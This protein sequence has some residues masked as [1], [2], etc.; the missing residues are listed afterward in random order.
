TESG[1]R[2]LRVER[3]T[4]SVKGSAPVEVTYEFTRHGPVIWKSGDRAV[5]VRWVGSEPGTAGYLGALAVGR[6]RNWNEFRRAMRRWKVPGEN[7]IYADAQ[8]HIGEQSAAL[9]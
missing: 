2:P 5:A 9:T 6:A 4:R 8:G 1:W 7:M 3:D